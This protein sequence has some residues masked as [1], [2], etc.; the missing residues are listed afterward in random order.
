VKQE[1]K[2]ETEEK[3]EKEKKKER[4]REKKKERNRERER[5]RKIAGCESNNGKMYKSGRAHNK[6]NT[7]KMSQL[8]IK[9]GR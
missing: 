8:T 1:K 6:F 2:R 3:R 7:T 9:R 5:E 4:A